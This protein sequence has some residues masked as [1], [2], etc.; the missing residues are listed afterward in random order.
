M[1]QNLRAVVPS[2]VL[3]SCLDDMSLDI[4]NTTGGDFA[5]S[6][7]ENTAPVAKKAKTVDDPL[8]GSIVFKGSKNTNLSLYYIDHTK[9]ANNGNGLDHYAREE[10]TSK[11]AQS[12]CELAALELKL[13]ELQ[14]ETVKLLGEPTNTDATTNLLTEESLLD[15]IKEQAEKARQLQVNEHHKQKVN[16]QISSMVTEWRKRRRICMDFLIVMEETTDGAVT[17]KKCM[18]G[19]GQIVIDSDEVVAKAAISYAKKKRDSVTNKSTG[20][21]VRAYRSLAAGKQTMGALLADENLVAVT[22]DSQGCVKR[23]YVDEP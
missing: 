7:E 16:K 12:K 19:D 2:P 6:D 3:K 8:K 9:L 22:L 18:N 5:D 10:L 4:R 17:M 11:S 20:R 13:K 15:E 23:V 14:T 1:Y 21:S